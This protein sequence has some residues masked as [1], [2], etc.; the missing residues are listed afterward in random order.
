MMARRATGQ[1]VRR[2]QPDVRPA[3]PRLRPTRVRHT[4]HRRRRLDASEGADGATERPRRRA[5]RHLAPAGRGGRAGPAGDAHLPRV[6]VGVVRAPEGRGWAARQ[7]AQRRRDGTICN[8]G[9]RTTCCPCS[10]RGGSIRSPSRTWT[11]T[12]WARSARASSAPRRST[13]R[14]RRSPR[15]WRRPSSTS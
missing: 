4:R 15:S 5:A 9:Y 8:G 12:G 1:V 6:R 3:L 14:S 11:A 7:W 13:R 10:R 2:A